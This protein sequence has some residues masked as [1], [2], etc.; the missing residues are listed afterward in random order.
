MNRPFGIDIH[1]RYT[2][3]AGFLVYPSEPTPKVKSITGNHPL[4]MFLSNAHPS[5]RQRQG[6]TLE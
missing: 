4:A 3:G 6:C 2:P 1:F 5:A